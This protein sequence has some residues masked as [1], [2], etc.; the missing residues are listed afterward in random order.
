MSKKESGNKD[1]KCE[2]NHRKNDEPDDRAEWRMISLTATISR[3]D[4]ISGTDSEYMYEL[5][6]HTGNPIAILDLAWPNGLQEGYS[7]PVA[8]LIN[9][10]QEV[11][12]AV[13]R[14]GFLFFTD[15]DAFHAYVLKE[16]LANSALDSL[17]S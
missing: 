11:E 16:I 15:A 14:A 2:A 12:E 9:E 6:D 7:Q 13:N 4:E 8:L 10:G 17:F 5:A 3:P 1:H